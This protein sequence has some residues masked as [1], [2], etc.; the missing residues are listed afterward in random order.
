M[1]AAKLDAFCLKGSLF[2]PYLLTKS[3]EYNVIRKYISI[4]VQ[5]IYSSV[6]STLHYSFA[7]TVHTAVHVQNYC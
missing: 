7:F 2:L 4:K 1:V 3:Y 6:D 5:E